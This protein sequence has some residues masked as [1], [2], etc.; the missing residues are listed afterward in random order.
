MNKANHLRARKAKPELA[1]KHQQRWVSKNPH[2]MRAHY[3]VRLAV[4]QGKLVRSACEVCGS[5]RRV[6][7]HHDDYS[8]PLVVVWLCPDHHKERH[9]HLLAEGRDPDDLYRKANNELV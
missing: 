1:V 8:K 9:K 6:S 5:T 4:N 3:Q 7:A 2:I